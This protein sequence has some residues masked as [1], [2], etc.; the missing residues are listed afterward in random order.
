ME[1]RQLR[2]FLSAAKH[3]SFTRAAGECCIVQSAMSQQI[4]ALEK[5][6]DVTLFDR[7]KQGLRL[8]PEGRIAAKEAQRLLNQAEDMQEAIR[9]ASAHSLIRVGCQGNLLRESLPR[10]L[11]EMRTRDP[12]ALVYIRSDALPKLMT[13][14]RDERLDCVLALGGKAAEAPD[15]TGIQPIAFET[16]CVLLPVQSPLA[17][18]ERVP[19]DALAGQTLIYCP[20]FEDMPVTPDSL[21]GK[22]L[23][24]GSTADVETLVAAGYGISFCPKSAA[25]RHPDIACRPVEGLPRSQLS[26]IWRRGDPAEAQIHAFASLLLMNVSEINSVF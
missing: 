3:L 10:V 1:L 22:S 11:A 23:R 24:V 7:T 25:P 8:T 14:L 19:A 2:Y 21:E 9:Q 18:R 16:I 20:D 12:D 6:L 26:L 15:W 17:A 5:E 13:A 4:R